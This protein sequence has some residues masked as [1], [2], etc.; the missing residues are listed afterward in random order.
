M[1]FYN[2]GK[3]VFPGGI[4]IVKQQRCS[5]LPSGPIFGSPTPV[6]GRHRKND[7]DSDSVKE[8]C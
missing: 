3:T 6:K 8:L 5:A 4:S 7:P 1:F 2:E